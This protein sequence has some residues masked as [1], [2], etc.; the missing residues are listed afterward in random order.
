MAVT[1]SVVTGGG[2][3]G[4]FV[5]RE[6]NGPIRDTA[7]PGTLVELCQEL[8]STGSSS[9]PEVVARLGLRGRHMWRQ[10]SDFLQGLQGFR[11]DNI[12]VD[13]SMLAE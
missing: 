9:S 6:D 4:K 3:G 7:T 8:F 12:S 5:F 13:V 2:G 1:R 11:Q 10:V